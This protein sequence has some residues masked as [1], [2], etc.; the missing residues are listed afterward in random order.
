MTEFLAFFVPWEFSWL[1]QA[2]V[3]GA[4]L[5]YFNGLRNTPAGELPGYG[6]IL[7]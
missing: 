7:E 5:L 4:L 1:V 6:P 3:W 2:S